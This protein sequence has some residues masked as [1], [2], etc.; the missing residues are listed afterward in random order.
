MKTEAVMTTQDSSAGWTTPFLFLCSKEFFHALLFDEGEIFKKA[1][2]EKRR[3]SRIDG[4]EIL[5]GILWAFITKHNGMI[6]KAL[7]S[8]FQKRTFFIPRATTATIR[9]SNTFLLYIQL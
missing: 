6:E 7:T 3:I 1:H 4:F 2:P 9:H 8:F 5:T